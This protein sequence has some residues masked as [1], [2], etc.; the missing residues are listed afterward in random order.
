M[1]VFGGKED[2][3]VLLEDKEDNLRIEVQKEDKEDKEDTVA[4]LRVCIL[5]AIYAVAQRRKKNGVVLLL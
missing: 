4:G 3:V 5:N 2:S 1:M